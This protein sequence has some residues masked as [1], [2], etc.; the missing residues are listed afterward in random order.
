LHATAFFAEEERRA[1]GGVGP[2][3]GAIAFSLTLIDPT[4]GATTSACNATWGHYFP[5][6]GREGGRER[7]EHERRF[8]TIGLL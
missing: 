6:S 1:G 4:T 7:E 2:G 8:K 5:K 3:P